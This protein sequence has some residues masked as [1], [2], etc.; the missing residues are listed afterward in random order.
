MSDLRRLLRKQNEM[1]KRK[2]SDE[3]V[4]APTESKAEGGRPGAAP[5]EPTCEKCGD[6]YGAPA[7]NAAVWGSHPFQAKAEPPQPSVQPHDHAKDDR[8]L[9][10]DR[11]CSACSAGDSEMEYH[12]HCPPFR[13]EPSVQGEQ[14]WAIIAAK[15]IADLWNLSHYGEHKTA[16]IIRKNAPAAPSITSAR[17]TTAAK[18]FVEKLHAIHADEKYQSVWTI[19]QIHVGPYQGPNYIKEL[20]ELE[21]ALREAGVRV[22]Q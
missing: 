22:E 13:V 5:N 17:I 15:E 11:P 1:F 21:K 12:S 8:K 3:Y 18:A 7:H 16:E 19:S 14:N 2:S 20:E 10:I 6:S 9:P 4:E